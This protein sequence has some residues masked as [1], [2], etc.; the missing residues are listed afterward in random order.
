ME[1]YRKFRILLL[2]L[3]FHF[4][5]SLLSAMDLPSSP[6][7]DLPYECKIA[8][9]TAPDEEGFARIPF[10]LNIMA[11]NHEFHDLTHDPHLWHQLALI[12]GFKTHAS[13]AY[14]A[15]YLHHKALALLKK[16]PDHKNNETL[17]TI[18]SSLNHAAALLHE[19]AII[20]LLK[21]MKSEKI[22]LEV[23]FIQLPSWLI[24]EQYPI[25]KSS[26]ILDGSDED[27]ARHYLKFG[28]L[29]LKY[30]SQIRNRF[31]NYLHSK[32]IG[33][34]IDCFDILISKQSWRDVKE[35]KI[36]FLMNNFLTHVDSFKVK[37]EKALKKQQT[38]T[39]DLLFDYLDSILLYY[40]K[41]HIG[42]A[43]N[44][45]G[46]EQDTKI[47]KEISMIL[48]IRNNYD[49]NHLNTFYC[50]EKSNLLEEE[51]KDRV[52]SV[53]QSGYLTPNLIDKLNEY[54]QNFPSITS[55]EGNITP[56]P[57][58]IY[59]SLL[60]QKLFIDYPA[61]CFA[62]EILGNH[63]YIE[64]LD[65]ENVG[66]L[67]ADN[68]Q[69]SVLDLRRFLYWVQLARL[70]CN[71]HYHHQVLEYFTMFDSEWTF[72]RKLPQEIKTIL[73]LGEDGST[74]YE[75][76]LGYSNKDDFLIYLRNK[77]YE[78]LIDL[79]IN[80]DDQEDLAVIHWAFCIYHRARGEYETSLHDIQRAF[81]IN[82]EEYLETYFDLLVFYLKRYDEA[83]D[84][85]ES[86]IAR[87][88]YP[89]EQIQELESYLDNLRQEDL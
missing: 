35:N 57:V 46:K 26:K 33:F 53:I 38:L 36:P 2:V 63:I 17:T 22:P 8:L 9:L 62:D 13:K 67:G 7:D 6:L 71:H 85:L 1:I 11:V 24:L 16:D 21:L 34:L 15:H 74:F 81:N 37:L 51:I 29:F 80:T 10:V 14:Q 87:K 31:Y 4:S 28:S 83:R 39:L 68:Y 27:I 79:L 49:S 76:Y 55:L 59:S 78:N 30:N 56:N 47:Q 88:F 23:N 41:I 54:S 25:L 70:D 58:I 44:L 77:Y 40:K 65:C 60:Q 42:T 43:E 75:T 32:N 72:F 19:G 69:G 73:N 52:V 61:L 18:L 89:K 50:L 66:Y 82:P 3:C 84:L 64:Q 86:D 45:I 12:D 5:L 20:Q 48:M